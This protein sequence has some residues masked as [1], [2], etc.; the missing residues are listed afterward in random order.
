MYCIE[1][2]HVTVSLLDPV[3]D[4]ERMG[5]RYCTGGY[6]FQVADREHGDLMSGPTY[7]HSYNNFDGQGMPDAFNL[8]PLREPKATEPLALILGIGVCDLEQN[9][10]TAW[11]DWNVDV[12]AHAVTMTTRQ[13]F[14]P[15]TAHLERTVSLSGRTVRSH[16]R[17][18]NE[19]RGALPIYWFP[20][21]F[22]PQ[23]DT[24]ELCKLNLPV[25]FPE[26][27]GYDQAPSR[28][29]RRKGWPWTQGHY[30]ILEHDAEQPLTII[31][32]HPLLGQVS[33]TCSYRPAFFPIWG[34]ERTFSWEP[35]LERTLNA[36][37]ETT[38]QIDYDF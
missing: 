29:I 20:H 5:T 12:Q 32:K 3:A 6:I 30:Q 17:V 10:V 7:P 14:G 19:G 16:T 28:F 15:F 37:Q 2:G 22:Y 35:F 18:S 25:R 26:N 11:C 4:Q 36:Q 34:N 24:D 8:R 33:A 1:N 21:P 31:Q 38:W 23:P 9:K 13:A 27:P